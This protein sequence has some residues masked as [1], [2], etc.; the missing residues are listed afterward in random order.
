MTLSVTYTGGRQG[1]GDPKANF[2][3]VFSGE[4]LAAN[5]AALKFADTIKTET[6]VGSKSISFPY[7]GAAGNAKYHVP[8][9][10][11]DRDLVENQI[12]TIDSDDILYKAAF[13][14]NADE[15]L[16]SYSAR[17]QIAKNI[18]FAVAT[19]KDKNILRT[20]V[21]AARS[22]AGLMTGEVG[23]TSQIVAN[24]AVDGTVLFNALL[25][26]QVAVQNKNI[27]PSEQITIALN[28]LQR[29]LLLRSD[30]MANRDYRPA[31]NSEQM[32]GDWLNGM[33]IIGSTNTPFGDTYVANSTTI[34]PYY[35]VD[36]SKTVGL[37][38]TESAACAGVSIPLTSRVIDEPLKYGASLEAHEMTA[39][40]TFLTNCAYEIKSA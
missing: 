5:Q 8:G 34:K 17:N 16:A 38:Y 22:T 1:S 35:N 13:V 26:A 19:Q 24:A 31:A 6:L 23:G 33:K 18:G 36:T 4:V 30:K 39:V 10:E 27:D 37:V 12:I 40:R 32:E 2:F 11:I 29:S 28:L 15:V 9:T 21:K 7:V 3:D 20:L 25:D 14:A